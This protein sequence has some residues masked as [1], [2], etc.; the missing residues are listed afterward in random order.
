MVGP[1]SH[2]VY[3]LGTRTWRPVEAGAAS[4]YEFVLD[5][6]IVCNGNF[7]WS[8]YDST[9]RRQIFCG[10]DFETE[11]F[12][13]FSPPPPPHGVVV[14]GELNVLRDC[15]CYSYRLDD[16][17]VIWLMKEYQVE[18]SWTVEYKLS[19]TD[20]YT[21]ILFYPIKVFK[22]GDILMLLGQM[23]LIYY[24]NKTRTTRQVSMFKDAAAED[25]HT[26]AM[27]FTPSLFSLKSFGVGN[28]ISF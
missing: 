23:W 21:Y 5:G 18:E 13:I 24:S 22:D 16:E 1:K 8:S 17:F 25:Y 11:C 28:V 27:I 15:L 7:H 19:A 20:W 6:H 14:C 26:S 4:G 9:G 2:H 3:T 10:F 12:S